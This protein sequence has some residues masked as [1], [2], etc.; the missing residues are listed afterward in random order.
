MKR[1]IIIKG[2]IA[3]DI[4]QIFRNKFVAAM[5]ALSI[6]AYAGIYYI[7]PKT[8]DETFDIAMYAPKFENLLEYATRG[9]RD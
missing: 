1:A 7:M 3:K 6:V 9:R 8:V 2:L 4:S 5:T